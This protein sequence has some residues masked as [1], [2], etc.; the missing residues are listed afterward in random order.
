MNPDTKEFTPL[1]EPED[2]PKD[3]PVFTVGQRVTV[4]GVAMAIRKVT[5]KDVILRPVRE[6]Q[7][8]EA[9]DPDEVVKRL[10][11]AMREADLAFQQVGGSTRHHVRDCLLP[12]LEKH[13]LRLVAVQTRE[14]L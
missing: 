14:A 6:T 7:N 5:R 10:T 2:A 12:V 11:A 8:E 1:Q 13:G 9:T 3:W 4:N